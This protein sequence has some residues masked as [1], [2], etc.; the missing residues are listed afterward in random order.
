VAAAIPVEVF[1]VGGR[2]ERALVVVKPPRHPRRTRIFKIDDGVLIAVEQRIPEGLPRLMH[3]PCEMKLRA[4]LD[5]L[6]EKSIE[7]CRGCRTIVTSVMKAQT[8]FNRV[9]HDPATLRSWNRTNT[10]GKP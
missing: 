4:G 1:R 5:T 10:H 2:Q 7:D 6:P 3:H 8:N 9:C